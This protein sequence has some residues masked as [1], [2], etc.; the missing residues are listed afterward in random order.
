MDFW[1]P[2]IRQLAEMPWVEVHLLQTAPALAPSKITNVKPYLLPLGVR[3]GVVPGIEDLKQRGI[4]LP[5]HFPYNSLVWPVRKR[6]GKWQ[7]I[8]D[9]RCLNANTGPLS[10]AVPNVAK[11]IATVQEQ[12]RPILAT[13]DVKDMFFMV[14]LQERD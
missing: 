6:N 10:T 3:E 9:Y 12:A 7:L 11:L 14:P 13:L 8:I 1:Y 5:T 2:Q 4:L